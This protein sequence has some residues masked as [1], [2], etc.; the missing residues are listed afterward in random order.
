RREARHACIPLCP[1]GQL[2]ACGRAAQGDQ[3][4]PRPQLLELDRRLP[5]ARHRRSARRG[6]R[7]AAGGVAMIAW[8]DSA[9][10]VLKRY[11]ETLDRLRPLPRYASR[12]GPALRDYVARMRTLGYKCEEG[13]F[14][15]FDRF[16]QQHPELA[17]EPLP[18]LI[19]AYVAEVRSPACQMERVQVGR[20]L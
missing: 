15:R 20:I 13:R 9:F 17:A 1:R 16:M 10:S 14:L 4:C 3:R 5:Q 18:P 19:R 12:F 6:A 2:V 7:S 11:I 8:P